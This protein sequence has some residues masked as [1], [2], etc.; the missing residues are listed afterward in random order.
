M[1]DAKWLCA[2]DLVGFQTQSDLDGFRDYLLRWATERSSGRGVLR[3]FGR[4]VRAQVFPIGIDVATVAG[5]A[6]AADGS[7]TCRGCAR[8]WGTGR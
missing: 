6:K 1:T 8:A 7:G 4:V 5:Q 2:Y 3:A